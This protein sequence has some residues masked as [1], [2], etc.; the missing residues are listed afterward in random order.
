MR[1]KSPFLRIGSISSPPFYSHQN[2]LS[3]QKSWSNTNPSF[4]ASVIARW[5][6]LLCLINVLF[7]TYHW[8]LLLSQKMKLTMII[9]LIRPMMKALL[10]CL[11]QSTKANLSRLNPIPK[12]FWWKV[13]CGGAQELRAASRGIRTPSVRKTLCWLFC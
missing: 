6:A 3:R 4:L 8:S 12:K 13:I 2:T 11:L 7:K 10:I 5:W 9:L 1:H